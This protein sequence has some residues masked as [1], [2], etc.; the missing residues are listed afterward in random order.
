MIEE[1]V[2]NLW[3]IVEE[4]VLDKWFIIEEE[5]LDK[6]FIIEEEVIEEVWICENGIVFIMEEKVSFK[7][8]VDG[9]AFIVVD[10]IIGNGQIS[11]GL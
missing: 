10:I 9:F 3:F 6:W 7:G 8:I 1:E 11:S 4:E 5:I 2:V